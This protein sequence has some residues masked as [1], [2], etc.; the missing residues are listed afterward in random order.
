MFNVES[1]ERAELG[2]SL[3]T[4]VSARRAR[5][6]GRGSGPGPGLRFPLPAAPRPERCGPAFMLCIRT[7][8]TKEPAPCGAAT[9]TAEGAGPAAGRC[10]APCGGA[11]CRAR[12]AWPAYG[13]LSVCV[14]SRIPKRCF[15][16]S[17]R[18]SGGQRYIGLILRIA[19]FC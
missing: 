15:S 17:R 14:S 11:R 6:T 1:L 2:E 18:D 5:A 8:V 3:L 7:A 12:P 10:P 9:G 19:F 16:P 13:F 4:W